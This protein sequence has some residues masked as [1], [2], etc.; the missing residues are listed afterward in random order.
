MS[1]LAGDHFGA[2]FLPV[3]SPPLT[4]DEVRALIAQAAADNA[5][6][7]AAKK[8]AEKPAKMKTKKRAHKGA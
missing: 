5:A 8:L 1:I 2:P 3:L 6:E 7:E 4:D